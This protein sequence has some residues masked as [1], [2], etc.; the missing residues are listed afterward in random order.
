MHSFWRW[1]AYCWGAPATASALLRT[2][3]LSVAVQ[4]IVAW[5]P[6]VGSI[7]CQRTGFSSSIGRWILSSRILLVPCA[8]MLWLLGVSCSK[9]DTP[10]ASDQVQWGQGTWIVWRI[11]CLCWE[12]AL[13][14]RNLYSPEVFSD[15]FPCCCFTPLVSS[16]LIVSS[17][18]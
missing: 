11:F 10:W 2:W 9:R 13:V 12:P 5:R 8:M 1:G 7:L 16:S 18:E 4:V 3:G 17:R 6:G 15:F 14:G